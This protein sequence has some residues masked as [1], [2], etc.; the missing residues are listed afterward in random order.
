M[1]TPMTLPVSPQ[2]QEMEDLAR[3]A[4]AEDLGPPAGGGDVTSKR[5]V[6]AELP[7]RARIL[8]KQGGVL[9]GTAVAATVF[10]V[11][12]PA[13]AVDWKLADGETLTPGA[14]V[15]ELSGRARAILAGERVALNFLQHLSGVAT[16]TAA[17]VAA[18]APH[19]V[20]VLC[21]RK[22]IPGMRAVQRA[23]VASGGGTLHRAG[24]YD[25]ILIKTSHIRLAG[26]IT[27]AI[28]RARAQ[29]RMSVEVEVTS[30][31]ELEEALA[32]E[33]EQILLDNAGPEAIAGA[34]AATRGRAF[35]E[36]SGGVTLANVA[37]IAA[38]GPD[39]VSVGA[40]THSS[41]AI[42][43]ALHIAGPVGAGP[44]A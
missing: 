22:T 7:S 27:E 29:P 37:A 19:G 9:A 13:L 17:F 44:R 28:R 11:V 15:A 41:P 30:A 21:T 23:A 16:Q 2:L 4:L 32:A 43:L 14:T 36:I 12:D 10:R 25:A 6:R 39:A 33:A 31:G 5:I 18:C 3:R 38:L 8:A 20:R 35:L 40:L 1:E 24:L 34:V 26:G 42:D